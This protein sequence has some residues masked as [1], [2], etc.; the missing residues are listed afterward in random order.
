MLRLVP[1]LSSVFAVLALTGATTAQVL[2]TTN[3]TTDKVVAFSPVDGSLVNADM[4]SLDSAGG[5][6]VAA[7]AVG[8]EIWVSEQIGDRIVRYD[9]GGVVNGVIGPTFP[10]GGFDNIRGMAL[11]GS[12]IYVT[13]DGAANGAT[14]DS[15]VLLDMAGNH[16]ATLPLSNSTSP[17]DVIAWQGD[18]LVSSSDANND[19][20]RYTTAGASVGVFHNSTSLNFSH[21]ISVASDGNVWAAGFSNGDVLKLDATTGAMLT[22]FVASG[23]RGVYELQ[24]GNVLWSSSS[25]TFVWDGTAS[26]LVHAG[27]GS[28]FHLAPT[29]VAFHKHV[30]TG[31]H[32]HRID[33]SNLFQLFGDVPAAKAALDGNA[34]R[35]TLSGNSYVANWIPGG[36]SGYITPSLGATIVAN[37]ST[38]HETFTPSAAIPVAGGSAS[39]WTVSSEGYLTAGS[40]GNQ[41]ASDTT[42]ALTD[43]DEETG[44]AFYTWFTQNPTEAGSGKIKWEE[45]AGKLC[46]TFEGVEC[47]AGTPTLSPSTYQFQI[48]MVTGEVTMLWVSMAPSNTTSDVLVG[49]T[50]AGAGLVPVS[51]TLSAVVNDT[52]DPDLTLE[53]LT[54]FAS[55]RP[56]INPSTSMTYTISNIPE[57]S[58]GSGLYLSTMFLSVTPLPGGVDL[59]GILTTVPGCNIYIATLDVNIGTAVTLAPTNV[60]PFTFSTPVFAP[61]NTI[62]AQ[63]VAFFDAAFPLQNGESSGFLFSNGVVSTTYVQ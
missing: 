62:G 54:L 8:L 59:T 50:L 58:P 36:A 51:Q 24:N 26:T 14:A 42:P 23:A 12:T 46:V 21:Q 20:H 10:G 19:V 49:C 63:A 30:G 9:H 25:G 60:V 52:V 55:P 5:N 2:V 3:T 13:N 15:L 29:G 45:V 47:A 32:T 44:L 17:F 40:V 28:H 53:P 39:S 37:V 57:T 22:S 1:S 16:I 41:L 43:T 18:L 4:I 11:I 33:Q 31:C 6:K 27:A 34:L 7:L 38:G 48:D 61:G 35:F 56:V